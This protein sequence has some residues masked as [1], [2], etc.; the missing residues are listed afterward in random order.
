MKIAVVGRGNVGGGLADLWEAAGH[1]V[2]R[3]GRDGTDVSNAE[4]LLLAVPGEAI[5][6]ALDGLRGIEGKTLIDPTEPAG[7]IPARGLPLQRRIREV[8]DQRPDGEVVQR[9]PR[10]GL[11][12]AWRDE[13]Y[14]EQPVVR[15][16]GGARGRRATEQGRGFRAALRGSFGERGGTGGPRHGQPHTG[17]LRGFGGAVPVQVRAAGSLLRVWFARRS[18]VTTPRCPSSCR[19]RWRC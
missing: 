18:T 16:R 9:Q 14:T 4:A 19:R 10:L 13:L 8:K 2:T 12:T 11:R 7:H 5:A 17:Y 1:E 3:I 6:D 15:R